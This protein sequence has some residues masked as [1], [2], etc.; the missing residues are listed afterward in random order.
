MKHKFSRGDGFIGTQEERKILQQL[1][2]NKGYNHS[3]GFKTNNGGN[4]FLW[5]VNEFYLTI[6]RS[7][8]TNPIPF[9]EFKRLLSNNEYEYEIY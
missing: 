9:E 7:G 4:D 6:N 2:I 8:I 3:P 5:S 1:I